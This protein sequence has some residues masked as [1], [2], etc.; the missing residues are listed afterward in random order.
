MTSLNADL[1]SLKENIKSSLNIG[2]GALLIIGAYIF[3]LIWGK[4]CVYLFDFHS[5][6]YEGNISQNEVLF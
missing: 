6:D 4:D 3:G 5:R 1:I 2:S